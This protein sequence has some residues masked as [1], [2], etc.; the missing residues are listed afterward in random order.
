M[1]TNMT[2]ESSV[3]QW[4]DTFKRWAKPLSDTEEAMAD[5]AASIIRNALKAYAPLVNVEFEV[6]A[7]GSYHNNTNVRGES[8]IDVAAVCHDSFFYDLP[9]GVQPQVVGFSSPASYTFDSFRGDVQ[10]AL[11]ARFGSGMTPGDKAFNVHEN[12]YRLEADVTPF[13]EYRRYKQTDGSFSYEEG[14]KSIGTSGQ[15]FVNWHKAHYAQGVKRNTA[16]PTLQ[17]HRAHSQEHQVRHACERQ[18][19]RKASGRSYP[20][21]PHRMP[22][23]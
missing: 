17:A 12:T 16:R 13:F 20:V 23:L 14:V 2:I 3:V 1:T 22:G 21:V 6:Y 9:P 7:T 10:A 19:E 5:N 8:D 4:D 11:A 18:R 15:H